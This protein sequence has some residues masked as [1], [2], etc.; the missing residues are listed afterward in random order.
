VD[1]N[2]VANASG[3]L[4]EVQGTAEKKPF[5]PEQLHAMVALAM[6]GGRELHQLQLAALAQAAKTP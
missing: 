2:V 4:L 1:L 3:E 6:R 5:T